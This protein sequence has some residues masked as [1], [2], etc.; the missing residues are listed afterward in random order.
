ME[1]ITKEIKLPGRDK[2]LSISAKKHSKNQK[3]S[4]LNNRFDLKI[5]SQIFPSQLISCVSHQSKILLKIEGVLNKWMSYNNIFNTLLQFE[6][7]KNSYFYTE[8]LKFFNN[9]RNYKLETLLS[10][11]ELPEMTV[12]EIEKFILRNQDDYFI[13]RILEY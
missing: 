13:K 3:D 7:F 12:D 6:R 9:F 10:K 2:S 5:A 4:K 8:Q 1:K 11:E